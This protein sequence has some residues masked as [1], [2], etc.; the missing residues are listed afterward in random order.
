MDAMAYTENAE[1]DDPRV[2]RDDADIVVV[3][4][5]IAAGISGELSINSVKP[6]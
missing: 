2:S 4:A 1:V 6:T 5:A 3:T